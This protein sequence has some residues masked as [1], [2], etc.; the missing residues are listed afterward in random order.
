MQPI[1]LV[2]TGAMVLASLGCLWDAVGDREGLTLYATAVVYGLILEKLVIVAFGAYTYPAE[3]YLFDALG[4]PLAIAFGWSAVI[5]AGTTTARAYGVPLPS[6]PGFVALYALHIDLSMDAI[7][8]RVP[9]WTW[10]PPGPWF[11]VPLGNFFGW[12]AVAFLFAGWFELLRR[13]VSHP[14]ALGGGTLVAALGTL[15]VALELWTTFVESVALGA[16]ILLGLGL[17]SALALVRWSPTFADRPARSAVAATLLFHLFFIGIF[18]VTGTHRT[19]PVLGV[20][21]VAALGVG[22]GVHAL[23]GRVENLTRRRRTRP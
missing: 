23:P 14:L 20:V 12:F 3:A 17:L 21:S 11:G 1:Y 19:L 22:V 7:A 15:L 10:T 2:F 6:L 4:V 13:R 9:F 8:I 5:Y 18:V 16:G